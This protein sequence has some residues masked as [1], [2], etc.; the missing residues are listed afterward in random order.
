[1]TVFLLLLDPSRKVLIRLDVCLMHLRPHQLIAGHAFSDSNAAIFIAA[2]TAR[3]RVSLLHQ[4]AL[5]TVLCAAILA[6][7]FRSDA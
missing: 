6:G 5:R 1:M 4:P 3:V 2:C 7:I